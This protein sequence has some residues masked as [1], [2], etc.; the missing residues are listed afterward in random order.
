M[1]QPSNGKQHSSQKETGQNIGNLSFF[2]L[3]QITVRLV[4]RPRVT[5]HWEQRLLLLFTVVAPCRV[6]S[7]RVGL[8]INFLPNQ[9]WREQQHQKHNGLILFSGITLW[10][11]F[12]LWILYPVQTRNTYFFPLKREGST[13]DTVLRLHRL[14]FAGLRSLMSCSRTFFPKSEHSDFH[15][16]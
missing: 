12:N 7:L 4:E 11:M 1:K 6:C 2:P 14:N 13:S 3:W 8:Q 10:K 5:L 16:I 15:L 9:L